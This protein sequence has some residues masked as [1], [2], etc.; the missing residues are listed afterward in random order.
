MNLAEK[1]HQYATQAHTGVVRKWTGEPY[2]EHPK[3]VA[4]ILEALDFP[5][6]VVAAAYLHD[7]V[8]DTLVPIEDIEEEFG[9]EVAALVAM[10]TKP[11]IDKATTTRA[12]RKAKFREQLA[13]TSYFGASLK[14]ADILDNS[15]NIAT[16]N[17]KF[18]ETYLPEL[19]A[20]VEVLSHG[21]LVLLSRVRRRLGI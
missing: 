8:E 14:L 12:F 21:N 4:A 2:I 5:E 9:F 19:R 15:S 17:P 13:Q 7:V 20:D 11:R 6:K 18:A 16:V 1:A 3:R 10:V